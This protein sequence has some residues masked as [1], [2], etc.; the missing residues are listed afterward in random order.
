MEKKRVGRLGEE[1][2]AALL[3]ERGYRIVMRN[4]SCKFGEVDIIARKGGLI[5][6]VE[7]KTRLSEDYGRG[8]ES[9][10]AAKRQRIRWCAEYYL[11]HTRWVY[12]TV[13]FQ[14]IEISAQQLKGLEF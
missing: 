14:V 1:L 10:T 12:D 8:R 9:V 6:F 13:D 5:A 4:F 7:V 2:A 11:S 3:E